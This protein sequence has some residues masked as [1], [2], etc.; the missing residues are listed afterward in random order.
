L[1][2]ARAGGNDTFSGRSVLGVA[3]LRVGI[4]DWS[5][6]GCG[7]VDDAAVRDY[8][9]IDN[10][11]ASPEANVPLLEA[12]LVGVDAPETVHCFPHER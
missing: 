2:A 3:S 4:R 1:L 9:A 11:P 12:E 10:P 5:A 8:T 7:E 6:R